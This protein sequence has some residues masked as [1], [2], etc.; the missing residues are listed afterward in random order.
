MASSADARML[1][2]ESGNWEIE[3][4]T[5]CNIFP[6]DIDKVDLLLSNVSI[7]MEYLEG[8]TIK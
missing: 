4:A 3:M 6:S 8:V 5:A 7:L 2:K 1:A